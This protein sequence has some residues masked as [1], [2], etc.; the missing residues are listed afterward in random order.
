MSLRSF[1]PYL[2]TFIACVAYLLYRMRTAMMAPR[3]RGGSTLWHDRGRARRRLRIS[4]T[5]DELGHRDRPEI[6]EPDEKDRDA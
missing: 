6:P 5:W 2:L 4:R 1:L 3:R